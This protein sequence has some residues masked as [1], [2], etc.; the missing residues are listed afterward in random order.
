MRVCILHQHSGLSIAA[1]LQ[2]GIEE[3]G[4]QVDL[5]DVEKER[6][7]IVSH[8][9][10]VVVGSKATTLFGGK[11]SEQTETFLKQGGTL[12]GKRSFA[13]IEKRGLRL[14]KSLQALMKIMESQG[15][16]ITYSDILN[17]PSY[18]YQVGKRLKIN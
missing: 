1:S 5:I 6:G 9:N 11:I 8:Y 10:Y 7:K 17:S 13:Y 4:H 3:Q 2:K 18:A 14:N 15:M 16:F 12:G